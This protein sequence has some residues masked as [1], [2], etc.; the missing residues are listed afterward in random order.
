MALDRTILTHVLQGSKENPQKDWASIVQSYD[1]LINA[2]FT[3]FYPFPV[4]LSPFLPFNF[5]GSPPKLTSC[6]LILVS[7][8]MLGE[9]FKLTEFLIHLLG[10]F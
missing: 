6:T 10:T 1:S 2:H 8:S 5:L 4:M 9:D 7:A 3:G